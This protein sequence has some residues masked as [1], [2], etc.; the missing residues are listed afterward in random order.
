MSIDWTKLSAL[1][2]E[3][4]QD[5]L[6]IVK[7]YL[8]ALAREGPDIFEG[9]IKHLGDGDWAKIDELMYRRMTP[10]E[11]RSLEDQLVKDCREAAIARFNRKELTKQIAFR[12]VMTILL[13]LV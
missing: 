13:R 11:R 8:P 6:S 12:A 5:L 2:D 4:T 3:T 9:F 1:A 7:P 10:Q